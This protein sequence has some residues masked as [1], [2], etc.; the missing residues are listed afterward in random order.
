[1]RLKWICLNL[2]FIPLLCAQQ[3][4]SQRIG[5]NAL[6]QM[7]A[8]LDEKTSRTPAQRKLDS[9]LLYAG[10][11]VR[12]IPVH[13]DYPVP[14]GAME[15][16]HPDSANMVDVDI[17]AQVT[18]QLLGAIANVGG[19]VENAL[20]GYRAVRARLPL[21][22]LEQISAFAEVEQIAPAEPMRHNGALLAGGLSPAKRNR[23]AEQFRKVFG[24]RPAPEPPTP[25]SLLRKLGRAFFAGPNISGDTAH[26]ANVARSLYGFTGAGVKIGV[27]SDGVEN[28]AAEQTAGRLPQVTVIQNSSGMEG[29]AILELVYTLA[30]GASLY[31]ATASGGAANMANNI[32]RL[33]DA[34]CTIILDDVSYLAE[35]VFQESSIARKVNQIAAQGVFYFS[36]AG[37]EGN[38]AANRSSVWVGDYKESTQSIAS[39]PGGSKIHQ[40]ALS[41]NDVI[42]YNSLL[43]TDNSGFHRLMWSD[44][45]G[46]STNDYDLFVLDSTMTSVVASSIG[47]QTGTQDPAETIQRTLSNGDRF[48]I[49]NY[50][51]TAAPRALSLA[52][53]GVRLSVSTQ[54]SI[55]GH[56]G[57]ERGF[58]VAAADARTAQGGPFTGGTANPPETFSADGPRRLFYNDDGSA[59]TPGNFLITTNGGRVLN[60]PDFTGADGVPTGLP[61]PFALF[62]GTSAAVGHPAAIAAL[63]R[64]AFPG[65]TLAQ[66]RQILRASTLDIGAPGFDPVSGDGIVM[67]PRIVSDSMALSNATC[68]ITLNNASALFSAAAGRG[69]VF[70]SAN[71][72]TWSGVSQATSWLTVTAGSPATGSGVLSFLL[73]PN[74][75]GVQ[76]TGII[77]IGSVTFTVTQAASTGGAAPTA[78]MAHFAAGGTLTT[79]FIVMNTGPSTANFTMNFF[80]DNGLPISIPLSGGAA[81]ILSG[82]VP[83]LGTTYY[84]AG[85]EQV[86]LTAGW[87]QIGA[88]PA[89]VIHA[90]FRN[91]S[92]N[93][94]Y[95]AAVSSGQGSKQFT[96]PFDATT[97]PGN[98]Q[99]FVTG[100]AVG[101]I[102]ATPA[103]LVCEARNSLGGLINGAIPSVAIAARGHWADFQFPLLVGQRGTIQCSSNT[104]VVGTVLRF[105]GTGPF[106]TLPVVQGSSSSG[107][108]AQ[109]AAGTTLTTGI[110]VMNTE[111]TPALFNI[112]FFDDSG[113]PLT[114]PFF[115]GSTNTLAGGFAGKGLLYYEASDPNSAMKVGWARVTADS[116]VV[117]H[118]LFRNQANGTY[119]EAAVPVTQGGHE[120]DFPFDAT[121]FAATGQPFVTGMAISNL[122]GIAATL[123]CTA[124]DNSGVLIAGAIPQRTLAA[125][126][127]WSDY[128]F[129]LLNGK[130]GMIRCTSNTNISGL[131]LRFMTSGAFSS[132]PVIVK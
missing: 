33:A 120:I 55:L 6:R 74:N 18:P 102:D 22:Q 53:F 119:Y 89:V 107:S 29:S 106:S 127:H 86:P 10:K 124:R 68:A 8:L 46:K 12:R 27:L 72:C 20:A 9:N 32:Q 58:S 35:G 30:P 50:N 25:G 37:N 64:Q 43:A 83:P 73:A 59:V 103:T 92:T 52:T 121:T 57:A 34:G 122:E 49:V 1:M 23:I 129:P 36:S 97:F 21:A 31:F 109:I 62:F 3:A 41:G 117:V 77:N 101:N 104:S 47:L 69:S 67:A 80:G 24:S 70:V 19:H 7:R 17:K 132:L 96:I 28:L 108:L 126:G 131:A 100:I 16:V 113:N 95:E 14:A 39:L 15:A 79:T 81:N 65:I 63:A 78:A 118:A 94:Y 45:L 116:S 111:S 54:G 125:F 38:K 87:A 91:H 66:M 84:E 61:S 90:L 123:S 11:I 112:T 105:L 44:P 76:R 42:Y 75:T 2:F 40:F 71:G 130:R 93:E 60:K 5:E 26:Q 85:S 128:Q 82:T 51:G 99:P 56:A 13:R 115:G 110:F 98:G 88:D 48:V 114:L 4:G